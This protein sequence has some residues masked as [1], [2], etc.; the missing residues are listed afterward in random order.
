MG[1]GVHWK[2]LSDSEAEFI[3][4]RVASR[5]D[6]IR[7]G[8]GGSN[9]WIMKAMVEGYRNGATSPVDVYRALDC[10]LPGPLALESACQ[11]CTPIDV[12]DPRTF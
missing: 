1:P 3:P 8:H 2:P 11:N 4:D 9:Y 10:S 6:A 5:A 12:S 7:T